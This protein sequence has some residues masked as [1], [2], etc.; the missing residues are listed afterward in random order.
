MQRSLVYQR[1]KGESDKPPSAPNS[2]CTTPAK[3][4]SAS[5]TACTGDLIWENGSG[6][7]GCRN[8]DGTFS[9]ERF[10]ANA[11]ETQVKMTSA[12]RRQA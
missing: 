12:P 1:A 11:R 4:P 6:Y 8:D 2:T 7:F 3:V 5:T 10:V 9:E